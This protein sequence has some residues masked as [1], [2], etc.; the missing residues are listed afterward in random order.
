M[1]RIEHLT[2]RTK[3]FALCDIDSRS[4]I[5]IRVF[6]R[7]GV[8]QVRVSSCDSGTIQNRFW[9]LRIA[10]VDSHHLIPTDYLGQ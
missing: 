2:P 8:D 10:S 6:H 5:R 9:S 4:V 3:I 7:L 1:P